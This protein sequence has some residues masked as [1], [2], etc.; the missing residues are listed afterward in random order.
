MR[1]YYEDY[2]VA[3]ETG[4]PDRGLPLYE[5]TVSRTHKNIKMVNPELFKY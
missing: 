5:K 1:P 2:P 3:A 4:S